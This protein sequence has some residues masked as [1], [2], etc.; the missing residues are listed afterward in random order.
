MTT[1]T[2]IYH[3]Q[4]NLIEKFISTG[5]ESY[6]KKIRKCSY[7]ILY[8]VVQS[9]KKHNNESANKLLLLIEHIIRDVPIVDEK[10]NEQVIQ[11]KQLV[12]L[13]VLY[14]KVYKCTQRPQ[15]LLVKTLMNL[16]QKYDKHILSNVI[17]G[18]NQL[19]QCDHQS[20][21]S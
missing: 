8:V 2:S 4:K 20:M 19:K 9:F 21:S 13:T 17:N 5:D 11:Y 7:S 6:L 1:D 14:I 18:Y 3:S 16:L 15:N 10:I 12:C